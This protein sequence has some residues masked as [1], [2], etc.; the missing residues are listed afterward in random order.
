M[1]PCY[2]VFWYDHDMGTYILTSYVLN[3]AN[4]SLILLWFTLFG[5][6]PQEYFIDFRYS[7]LAGYGIAFFSHIYLTS[8][9]EKLC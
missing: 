7:Y 1:Q 4:L 9:E 8:I 5:G 2:T 3:F 6:L